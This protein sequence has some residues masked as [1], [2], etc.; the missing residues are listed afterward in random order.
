MPAATGGVDDECSAMLTPKEVVNHVFCPRFTW[1]AHIMGIPERAGLRY[2]VRKGKAVHAR[3]ERENRGYVRKKIGAVKKEIDVYLA[4]RRERLRGRV[5]EVVWLDDGCVAPLDYK[6]TSAP[7]RIYYG[8]RIQV[9][10]YALMLRDAWDVGVHRAFVV[11]IRGGN[12][13]MEV[14]FGER[15]VET[16]R[17][18]VD[19]VFEVI[20]GGILPPRTRW[21]GRCADCHYRNICV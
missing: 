4:S 16:C 15:E 17:R 9:S 7:D 5:D 12:T 14:P 11:Y 13:V 3:R 20:E 21:E 8:H 1:F 6:Y 10:L 19:E 2:K 18:L